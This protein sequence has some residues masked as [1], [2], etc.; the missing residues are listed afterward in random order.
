MVQNQKKGISTSSEKAKSKTVVERKTNANNYSI[1]IE[2]EGYSKENSGSLTEK[3]IKSAITVIKYIR[4]EVR[5]I[6]GKM[7]PFNKDTFL[8]HSDINTVTKP[9]CPGKNYPFKKIINSV[10]K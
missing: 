2:H 8:G 9:F 1:T 6:Y 4:D 3:Q 7:I 5:R 10:T